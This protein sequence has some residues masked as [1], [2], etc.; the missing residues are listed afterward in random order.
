MIVENFDLPLSEMDRF[1]RQ[2]ISKVKVELNPISQL[3]IID[4]YRLFHPTTAEHTCFSG[5]H[6]TFTKT[7]HT[8]D[9]KIHLNDFKRLEIMQ[10]SLATK[11]LYYKSITRKSQNTW[12]LNTTLLKNISAKE[13]MS[14]EI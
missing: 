11:E 3:D 2:K 1:S 13:E 7:N 9:H 5:S 6:G 12:R 14:R 8:L 10:C 4:I